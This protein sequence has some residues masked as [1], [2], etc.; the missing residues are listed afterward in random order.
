MDIPKSIFILRLVYS[1]GMLDSNDNAM[2]S[3]IAIPTVFDIHMLKKAD[4]VIVKKIKLSSFPFEYFIKLYAIHLSN[5]YFFML[6]PRTSPPIIRNITGCANG[7][8]AVWGV[9]T[10]VSVRSTGII[11][12]VIGNG[13]TSSTQQADEKTKTASVLLIISGSENVTK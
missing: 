3:I 4:T 9:N 8:K 12:P 11:K 5:S 6:S 2:G 13:N 10:P 7:M 1:F